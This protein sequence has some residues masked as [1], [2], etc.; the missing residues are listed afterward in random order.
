MRLGFEAWG[1]SSDRLYTGMGQYAA[2]LLQEITRIAPEIS[3]IAYAACDQPRPAWLPARVTWRPLKYRGPTKLAALF[4]RIFLLPALAR[5]DLLDLFHAP[6]VYIRPSLPPV[7]RLACPTVV[8]LHDL[9]PRAFYRG[10][11]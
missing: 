8:T 11:D 2:N 7:P 1:L 6:A 9:I 3:I 10:T 4:S 5:R